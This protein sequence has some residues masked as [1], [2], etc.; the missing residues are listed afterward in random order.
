MGCS[1]RWGDDMRII[2]NYIFNV[3][4]LLDRKEMV[5]YV[6]GFLE[7]ERLSYQDI[8]FNLSG[9]KLKDAKRKN[10][11]EKLCE[12]DS[13]WEKYQYVSKVEYAKDTYSIGVSNLDG[14]RWNRREIK[15]G[16]DNTE[17]LNKIKEQLEVMP[18]DGYRVAFNDINW[19]SSG[20]QDLPLEDSETPRL[21]PLSSNI[22]LWED[23]MH[24]R[25]IVLNFEMT[26]EDCEKYVNDFLNQLECPYEK[27][28][29]FVRDE[30]EKAS[31]HKAYREV[32]SL[33]AKI[34]TTICV[35]ET[36]NEKKT[37]H[38]KKMLESV[39]GDAGFQLGG[40]TNG[41]YEFYKIDCYNHLLL[42]YFDY[43]K[44]NKAFGATLTYKGNG[45]KHSVMYSDM[46]A[47]LCDE[48]IK[49]YALG[50]LKST[51]TFEEQYAPV[52]AG[53]YAA[54]PSW[55]EWR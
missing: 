10:Y 33:L 2:Y 22:T 40:I 29:L 25:Y 52:I 42:L 16:D 13:F 3:T 7:R 28:V 18:K 21:Y 54:M 44:T 36:E 35:D 55:F 27:E 50:I 26:G 51:H 1:K 15:L 31:Y 49:K 11:Y 20:T 41:L 34:N 19:F 4:S 53:K 5:P 8:L 14:G 30:D 23:Y 37:I 43:E 45:Y 9:Y 46:K 17:L 6:I 47:V 38:I 32:K 39:F 48:N 24:K 12:R